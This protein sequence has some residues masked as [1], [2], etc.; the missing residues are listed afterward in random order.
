MPLWVQPQ[1]ASVA[2]GSEVTLS[3]PA[4]VDPSGTPGAA[5]VFWTFSESGPPRVTS[6]PQL[7]QARREALVSGKVRSGVGRG[8]TGRLRGGRGRGVGKR[9]KVSKLVESG[10]G[11]GS[12]K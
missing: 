2:P 10:E 4:G 8:E 12:T 11:T 9:D 1:N 7:L 5:A 6:V 3:C